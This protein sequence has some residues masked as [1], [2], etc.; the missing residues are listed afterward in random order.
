MFN[1]SKVHKA[2]TALG[3]TIGAISGAHAFAYINTGNLSIS[4]DYYDSGTVGYTRAC[5]N[6]TSPGLG[7]QD[8]DAAAGQV[9]GSTP[10][11][12]TI[13]LP[14]GLGTLPVLTDTQGIFRINTIQ[15]TST[16]DYLYDVAFDTYFLTGIFSGIADIQVSFNASNPA[17]ISTRGQGGEINIFKNAKNAANNLASMALCGPATVAGVRDLTNMLYSGDAACPGAGTISGGALWLSADFSESVI[18][19]GDAPN[20]TFQS[21][22]DTG[23]SGS[24]SSSGFLNITGGSDAGIFE[25]NTMQDTLGNRHD[26]YFSNSFNV[27]TRGLPNPPGGPITQWNIRNNTG[28]VVGNVPEP[29]SLALVALSLLGLGAASHRRRKG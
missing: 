13:N 8:C 2:V 11:A 19:A 28:E 6:L 26:L 14:N 3:L 5:G 9:A 7:G 15:N 17:I 25:R 24:G 22:W 10:G 18:V 1:L 20:A 4:L 12:G 16:G 27:Q 29:G 21:T 23:A